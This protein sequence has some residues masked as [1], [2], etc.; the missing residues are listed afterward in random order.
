L[1]TP[2]NKKYAK[3]SSLGVMYTQLG[4]SQKMKKI[5]PENFSLLSPV[6]LTTLNN[7]H[8]QISPRIFEKNR[9]DPNGI[10]RGQGDTDLRKKP[11][12]ENLVSDSL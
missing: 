12:V 7:I 6:S 5:I 8:S 9:N 11:E 2:E 10:L 1:P 4:S 3:I